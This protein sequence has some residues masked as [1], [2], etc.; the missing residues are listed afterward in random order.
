MNKIFCFSTIY[1]LLLVHSAPFN[2][3]RIA[4]SKVNATD[5]AA[6]A[7]DTPC[8]VNTPILPIVLDKKIK[9]Y[10]Q[11]INL[12]ARAIY[13]NDFQTA[14][15]HYDSAFSYRKF[16]YYEDIKTCILVNHKAG[17]PDK[18]D[19]NIKM[20]FKFKQVDT[21]FLFSELPKRVFNDKNM[22]LIQALSKQKPTIPKNAKKFQKALR[23]MFI[24]DQKAHSFEGFNMTDSLEAQKAYKRR[25]S[26]DHD[27]LIKFVNL[28]KKNGFPTEEKIGIPYDKEHKWAFINSILLL[29]F[30]ARG[31]T[32]DAKTT[33]DMMKTEFSK[34][35]IHPS[36]YASSLDNLHGRPVDKQKSDYNFMNTAYAVVNGEIYRPF[37]FYNDSLMREVNTNRISVGLDSFH[38]SQKQIICTIIGTKKLKNSPVMAMFQ[39][40]STEELSYGFVKYAFEQAKMNMNTYK[41][42]TEK[43]LKECKCEEKTY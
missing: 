14:S 38:T 43:I 23:E 33:L 11:F 32:T 16:P 35:N 21:A 19:A 41:I 37:V 42:N 28:C 1:L 9:N 34:G 17:M 27:N 12:A 3:R 18:N 36:I 5:A 6:Q 8:S 30:I 7:I 15:V 39:Y 24:I 26:I 31:D 29:H 13:K 2:A 22:K 4:S 40:P 25:D 20:L 10:H